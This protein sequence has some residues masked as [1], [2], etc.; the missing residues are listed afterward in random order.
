MSSEVSSPCAPQQ[1]AALWHPCPLFQEDL[2]ARCKAVPIVAEP[3][4]QAKLGVC[5]GTTPQLLR[6][7]WVVLH[8]TGAQ[9]IKT[10][11]HTVIQV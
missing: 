1:A 8:G 2:A 6:L 7:S 11:V 3:C 9:W 5:L 10:V 4:F